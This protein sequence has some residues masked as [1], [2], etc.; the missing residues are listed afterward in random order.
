MPV[1]LNKTKLDTVISELKKVPETVWGQYQFQRELLGKRFTEDEKQAMIK[2]AVI[3]GQEEA[4]KIKQIYPHHNIE[5]I[6][7]KLG[8]S[9]QYEEEEMIGGRLVLATFNNEDGVTFMKKPLENLLMQQ[10]PFCWTE[11]QMAAMILGHELF[12]YIETNTSQIYT[13]STKITLWRLPF[14]NHRSSIRALSE[15]AAMSFSKQLNQL[16]F[17]PY[18]LE[19]ILLWSYDQQRVQT[20]YEEVM[21]LMEKNKK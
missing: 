15:I 12:H 9:I 18:L 10:K 5:E 4:A 19:I 8:L 20:L 11:E 21:E 2:K 7:Q 1:T 16:D 3:C 13:Q 17:S 6:Y 14:Y